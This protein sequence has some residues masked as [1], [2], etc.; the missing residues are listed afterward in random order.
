MT[1][2]WHRA[3]LS[4]PCPVA[5][6]MLAE[7]QRAG[8]VVSGQL[9]E[10]ANVRLLVTDNLGGS[11]FA[12]AEHL[13][14]RGNARLLVVLADTV[15][16]DLAPLWTVVGCGV[17]DVLRLGDPCETAR[18]ILARIER[19]NE[20]DRILQTPLVHKNLIGDS[21]A[22]QRVLRQVIELAAFT[23][24]SDTSCQSARRPR[25]AR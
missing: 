17:A 12:E 2:V 11:L 25:S 13:S 1:T 7:L 8:I 5:D 14:D 9:P 19:W 22:L 21:P 24:G 4:A 16:A 10:E 20:V 15:G 23:K 6:R 18:S 3:L